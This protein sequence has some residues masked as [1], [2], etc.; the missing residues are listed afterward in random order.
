MAHFAK[1]GSNNIVEEVLVVNNDVIT[2]SDGNEQE[3]LGIDFLSNLTG[4]S[5]WK[6]TS[7]NTRAGSHTAGGTPLRKN[8]A[9]VGY[10]YDA[11]KD[12]FYETQPFSSWTLNETSCMWEAPLSLPSDASDEILYQWDED[13]YQADNTK[14]WVLREFE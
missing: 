1:I 3:Q 14:G 5:N 8:Y 9:V 11:T 10:I 12:A 6:Q 7:Y 13:A 4:H 2:D